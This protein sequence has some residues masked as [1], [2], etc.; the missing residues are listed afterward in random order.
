MESPVAE[1]VLYPVTQYGMPI[2]TML[3]SIGVA[4]FFALILS[5]PLDWQSMI[6]IFGDLS[7][8]VPW[9]VLLIWAGVVRG[10]IYRNPF[11]ENCWG[12]RFFPPSTHFKKADNVMAGHRVRMKARRWTLEV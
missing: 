4:A 3:I 6:P 9:G 7:H 11:L 1:S 8:L 12:V 2:R 10:L 5:L